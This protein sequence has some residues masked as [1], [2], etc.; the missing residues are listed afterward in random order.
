MTKDSA[1]LLF[2]RTKQQ[3]ETVAPHRAALPLPHSYTLPWENFECLC[4]PPPS[5]S[6]LPKLTI[7]LSSSASCQQNYIDLYCS[8]FFKETF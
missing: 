4:R 1:H 8:L 5:P 3:L 6:Q 2:Q 7:P